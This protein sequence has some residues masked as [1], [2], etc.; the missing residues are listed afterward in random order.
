MREWD[1]LPWDVQRLYLEGLERE[2]LISSD[3]TASSV[4]G[5]V[6]GAD[7]IDLQAD[8]FNVRQVG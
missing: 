3:S 5:D 2:E 1:D 4:G 7:L 8:G 6:F